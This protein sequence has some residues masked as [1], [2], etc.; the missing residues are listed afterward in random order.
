MTVYRRA[1]IS[2]KLHLK[3]I[4]KNGLATLVAAAIVVN[5]AGCA[6]I[7]DRWQDFMNRIS[8]DQTDI[9]TNSGNDLAD[10]EFF[11]LIT[12]AIRGDNDIGMYYRSIPTRQL[13]GLTIDEFQRYIQLLRRG[14]SGDI[15]SF[16]SMS[17]EDLEKQR[18]SMIEQLPEHRALIESSFAYWIIYRQSGKTD[19]KFAFYM[20]TDDEDRT[21]LSA[22][23]VRQILK[24]ADYS[25]LYFDAIDRAQADALAF[26]IDQNE[27]KSPVTLAKAEK[28]INFYQNNISSR[29]S[30][31]SLSVARID[32][33]AFDQ[34]GITNLDQ[35]QS[36][37]RS[38]G[39]RIDSSGLITSDDYIQDV[40]KPEDIE[41]YLGDE[42]VFTL[43][44]TDE[45][46]LVKVRSYRLEDIIGEPYF[47]NDDTCTTYNDGV[48]LLK[49]TYKGIIVSARGSC[50]DHTSWNGVVIGAIIT[51]DEFKLGS[52]L[53][54]NQTEE[55][56]LKKY[57]FIKEAGYRLKGQYEGGRV[58]LN[59]SVID[60][61]IVK[62]EFIFAPGD[63]FDV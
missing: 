31:Y 61:I 40:L 15:H 52:G 46:E 29:T 47:H 4:V 14:I 27:A 20:Q 32:Y 53:A 55:E 50:R 16:T 13:D 41:I 9:Y 60:G 57:P 34:F 39:F 63:S 35:T 59:I 54:V 21:Y 19:E 23:W 38:V 44:E 48:S 12:A 3:K 8:G 18:G 11:Q 33:L 1:V 2:L 25:T 56:L 49:L 42:L 28:L 37:S 10:I 24:L 45:D 5:L 17:D 7:S 6:R 43:G 26:L 51:G 58:N 30:E 36:V 62:L 22:E